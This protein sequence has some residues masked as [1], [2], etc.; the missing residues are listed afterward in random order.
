MEVSAAWIDDAPD[1]HRR[2]AEGHETQIGVRISPGECHLPQ[3]V[4]GG[5]R[6]GYTAIPQHPHS[7]DERPPGGADEAN[8]AHV[9][10]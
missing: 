5:R 8:D 2:R 3:S 7:A 6:P 9:I 10:G 1:A 4:G